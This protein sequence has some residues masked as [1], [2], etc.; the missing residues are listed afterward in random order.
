[1][2]K[3][4][5]LTVTVLQNPKVI[6]M[7]RLKTCLLD[8][9]SWFH[10]YCV[11]NGLRYYLVEGSMLGCA[12]HHGF[13][14]W[15]DDID[16]GMPRPDYEKLKSLIAGKIQNSAYLLETEESDK[17][18]FFYTYSKLFD[19]RTTQVE[20][21]RINVV[22]GVGID[23]FPIDGIGETLESAKSNYKPIAKQMDLLTARVVAVRPGRKWYK[24]AAVRVLQLVPKA[25]INEK[26]IMKK[27]SD[28]C[29]Q[30]EYDSSEYV[31][32]LVTTYR[33]KEIIPRSFYGT[34]TIYKFEDIEVYGVEKFDE[35]LTHL[36]GDWR[37][38]PPEDKRQTAHLNLSI[39]FDHSYLDAES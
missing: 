21:R 13:I 6:S 3:Q 31:G 28:M 39:D 19:V 14:P 24:N 20:E 36:Y 26:K 17:P 25:F 35:Y 8:M 22:R 33:A 23:V 12:R 32:A 34:P 16:I 9:L 27:I 4:Q 38:P 18:E 2:K 11:D 15:D 1:M 10:S 30:R 29:K 5:K 7:D 37:Q